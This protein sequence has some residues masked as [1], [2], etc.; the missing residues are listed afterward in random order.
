M[1]ERLIGD[2]GCVP[3]WSPAPEGDAG[4]PEGVV[5]GEV[6]GPGQRADGVAGAVR[7]PEHSRHGHRDEEQSSSS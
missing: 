4:S 5:G 2:L 6:P 3:S 7:C 1:H